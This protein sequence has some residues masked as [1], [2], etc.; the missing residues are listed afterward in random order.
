MKTIDD[1]TRE[2]AGNVVEAAQNLLLCA[3]LQYW[4]SGNDGTEED[5]SFRDCL[6]QM[7]VALDSIGLPQ[8]SYEEFK[9]NLESM[10]KSGLHPDEWRKRERP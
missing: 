3:W 5:R 9:A 6:E 7:A 2:Q 4:L 1:M 8:V 10:L